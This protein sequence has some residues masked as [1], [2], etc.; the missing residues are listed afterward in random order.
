LVYTQN[1]IYIEKDK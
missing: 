1:E